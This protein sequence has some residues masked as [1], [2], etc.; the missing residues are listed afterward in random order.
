MSSPLVLRQDQTVKRLGAA[1]FFAIGI[2]LILAAPQVRGGA[3]LWGLG[4]PLLLLATGFLLFS[5]PACA[6]INFDSRAVVV[7]HGSFFSRAQTF[8]FDEISRVGVETYKDPEQPDRYGP[9]LLCEDGRV[10]FLPTRSGSKMETQ[11]WADALRM[12]LPARARPD[13]AVEIEDRID[14]AI[15]REIAAR[16]EAGAPLPK[17]A[18]K[19]FGKRIG[20]ARS[21]GSDRFNP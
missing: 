12:A 14:V 10:T 13:G 17:G 20:V 8:S 11:R 21:N 16:A 9:T 4:L 6:S 15:A 1:F 18:G 2:G 5:R 3:I 7:R 19:V